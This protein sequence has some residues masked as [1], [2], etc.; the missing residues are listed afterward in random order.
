MLEILRSLHS[1]RFTPALIGLAEE[2]GAS[3]KKKRSYANAY[4]RR[5]EGFSA[6]VDS[7]AFEELPDKNKE[8]GQ[9]VAKAVAIPDIPEA[10]AQPV[11]GR[12]KRAKRSKPAKEI[13]DVL[14]AADAQ[15]SAAEVRQFAAGRLDAWLCN[16]ELHKC[17]A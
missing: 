13:L 15:K 6:L 11:E 2:N 12:K 1:D 16:D 10:E 3:K 5:Y 14:E 8:P 17:I 7:L 4:T 9:I